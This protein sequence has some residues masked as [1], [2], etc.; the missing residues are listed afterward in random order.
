[1]AHKSSTIR[2]NNSIFRQS[3]IAGAL[4]SELCH[5]AYTASFPLP[6][7]ESL[8][9]HSTPPTAKWRTRA[10]GGSAARRTDRHSPKGYEKYPALT[11]YPA[12]STR[13]RSSDAQ[14]RCAVSVQVNCWR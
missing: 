9:Q 4:A 11:D 2:T 5:K 1:M 3:R 10:I 14:R 6:F 8:H 7:G 13:V 12:P